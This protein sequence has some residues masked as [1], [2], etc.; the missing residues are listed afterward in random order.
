MKTEPISE[1]PGACPVGTAEG[2]VSSAAV[3]DAELIV[4]Q[5]SRKVRAPAEAVFRVFCSL[6]GERG[7]MYMNWAWRLR[8]AMDVLAGGVGFRT[9]SRNRDLRAGDVLDFWRVDAILPGRRLR[10]RA[11]MKLPGQGWLE[12]HAEPDAAGGCTLSQIAS[13]KP[14]GVAGLLYW[15]LFLPAHVL[16][17]RGMIR[18][19]AAAA[20]SETAAPSRRD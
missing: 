10:L 20:E 16:I 5:R 15:Y 9:G 2:Q 7:W 19:I 12:F 18:S 8:Q 14:H 6:G 11:E 17:F 1:G 13:F 4:N 3:C